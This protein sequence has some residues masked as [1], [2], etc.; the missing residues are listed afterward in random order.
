MSSRQPTARSDC[1]ALR[2]YDQDESSIDQDESS[3]SRYAPNSTPACVNMRSVKHLSAFAYT[4][5]ARMVPHS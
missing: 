1:T 2:R 3:I 4:S 5:S